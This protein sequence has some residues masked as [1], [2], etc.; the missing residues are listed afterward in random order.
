MRLL[1][2]KYALEMKFSDLRMVV[3]FFESIYIFSLSLSPLVVLG[4]VGNWTDEFNLIF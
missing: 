1:N 3:Y 2:E 4:G